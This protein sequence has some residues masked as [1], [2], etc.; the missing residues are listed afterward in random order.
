MTQ[1]TEPL[2]WG[3]HFA[4]GLS[5][6]LENPRYKIIRRQR[7]HT[8][9]RGNMNS[10]NGPERQK[11]AESRR[12]RTHLLPLGVGTFPSVVFPGCP[13]PSLPGDNVEFLFG[14]QLRPQ[15]LWKLLLPC[16]SLRVAYRAH[17]GDTVGVS[18]FCKNVLVLPDKR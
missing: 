11:K 7:G 10:T 13:S 14:C 17:M 1:Q 5:V 18:H 3:R 9:A 12:F 4:D 8:M 15:R 6:D 2:V 16:A